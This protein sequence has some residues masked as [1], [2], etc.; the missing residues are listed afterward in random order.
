MQ[1]S[2]DQIIAYLLGDAE[3]KLAESIELQLS[4][5]A[6]LLDRLSQLRSMLGHLDSLG[7]MYEPPGDLVDATLERIEQ[8]ESV[9]LSHARPR[10]GLSAAF[11]SRVDSLVLTISLVLICCMVLPAVIKARFVARKNRC[12]HNLVSNGHDLIAYSLSNPEGRFPF[13]GNNRQTGFAGIYSVHLV[14]A[15]NSIA[16]AQVACPSMLGTDQA[17]PNDLP[18]TI[19][20][21]REIGQLTSADLSV[22]QRYLGGNYAY[23]IGV[24]EEGVRKAP[25]NEGRANFAILSDA[26]DFVQDGEQFVA[27]D[28]RGINILFEDGHVEFVE[29]VRT[30]DLS[31]SLLDHPFRNL[32]GVHAAGLNQSDAFLA[33]SYFT[34]ALVDWK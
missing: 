27:H 32:D 5:D 14:D 3:P 17:L 8:E 19:P 16:F 7:G 22:I 10:E 9:S 11:Q 23:N 31:G 12:E 6:D 34:P 1:F 33:P 4:S 20:G 25:K 2:D 28:G 21:L 30:N 18:S 29:V 26:P 15:G 13:V 24:N